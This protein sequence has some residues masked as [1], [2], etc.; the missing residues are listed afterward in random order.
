M[1][2]FIFLNLTIYF[3]SLF[4]ILGVGLYVQRKK[5]KSYQIG[6]K[7]SLD[8]VTL[9]VPF[10]NEEKRIDGLLKSLSYS[11]KL[12]A[13]IIFVNDHSD[14]LS[15][16]KI[17]VELEKFNNI[18]LLNLPTEIYGK[19]QAI[20]HG[21]NRSKTEFILTMDADVC[22]ESTYF[23]ELE[24]LAEADLYLLPAVLK[25]TN[26]IHHLFEIDLLL[27]NALN[28]GLNG[29]SRPIIASG[30]N[31]LFKRKSF[32]EF[33]RFDT[34]KHIPSGDDIY[35]LR[36]FRDAKADI[37]LVAKKS[38]QVETETPQSFKEFIHQ[39]IRWIAKTGN[40]ND[41]LST[42]LAI[43]QFILMI[44][45]WTIEINL[46]FDHEYPNAIILFGLKTALDMLFFFAFFNEFNRLTAWLLIPFYQLIFPIYNLILLILLPFFKP[47]WKG[48]YSGLNAH[49]QK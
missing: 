7:I 31:L 10:R 2:T 44:S 41:Q 13:Q 42:T 20:R 3:A 16:S 32:L 40:V 19:K 36:D 18:Q 26:P 30:A 15:S 49:L 6:K 28:T 35:L 23:E 43:I 45:F 25:A 11:R 48:R 39:R 29:L 46:L 8:E 24:K 14:D 5:E 22:F 47:K 33:D 37:R 1:T 38:F 4:L 12:P 17:K 34:H 21:I 9:I 27:I